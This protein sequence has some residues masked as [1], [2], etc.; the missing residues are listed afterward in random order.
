MVDRLNAAKWTRLNDQFE[1]GIFL[2]IPDNKDCIHVYSL[3]QELNPIPF[4]G[5]HM[6]PRQQKEL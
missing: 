1:I 4:G 3:M 5:I 2:Q 6:Q